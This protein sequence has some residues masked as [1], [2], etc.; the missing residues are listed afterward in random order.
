MIAIII[1][2]IPPAAIITVLRVKAIPPIENSSTSNQGPSGTT[3]P[4][5]LVL[6]VMITVVGTI[7]ISSVAGL[8]AGAGV[9]VGV[10]IIVG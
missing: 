6:F 4:S 1:P 8:G 9:G 2:A 3:I 10:G 5:Q 7:T